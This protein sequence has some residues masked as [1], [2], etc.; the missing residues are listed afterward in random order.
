MVVVNKRAPSLGGFTQERLAKE[1]LRLLL[2]CVKFVADE[3][4]YQPASETR[5]QLLIGKLMRMLK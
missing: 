5:L 2:D 4:T 3:N 1:D